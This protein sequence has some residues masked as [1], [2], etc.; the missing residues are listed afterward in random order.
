MTF[1]SVIVRNMGSKVEKKLLIHQ[2]VILEGQQSPKSLD[3]L[4]LPENVSKSDFYTVN[5]GE[6]GPK[7]AKLVSLAQ[8]LNLRHL[9]RAVLRL[10][11][12]PMRHIKRPKISQKSP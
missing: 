10:Q 7:V 8:I 5:Q 4:V 1:Y 12:S 9:K 6:M 2:W 3:K 11:N